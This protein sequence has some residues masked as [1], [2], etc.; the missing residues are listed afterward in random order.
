MARGSHDAYQ[1]AHHQRVRTRSACH[2]ATRTMQSKCRDVP[3][4]ATVSMYGLVPFCLKFVDVGTDFKKRT[5]P[6]TSL[7]Y[8]QITHRS[9]QFVAGFALLLSAHV[10]LWSQAAR[11]MARRLYLSPYRQAQEMLVHMRK[12][13][14]G[15]D[16]F[17]LRQGRKIP[18]PRHSKARSI[19]F[20]SIPLPVVLQASG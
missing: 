15:Q 3:H 6:P 14:L 2:S 11:Q 20:F 19:M 13:F 10:S 9:W 16:R 5:A 8:Q 17:D 12:P 1:S 7:S 4:S 18:G